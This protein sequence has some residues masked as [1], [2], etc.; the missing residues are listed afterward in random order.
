MSSLHYKTPPPKNLNRS[1]AYLLYRRLQLITLDILNYKKEGS[2]IFIFI[3][4]AL[5][6]MNQLQK[7]SY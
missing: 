6:L 4:M 3:P 5:T 7:D 2:S 1:F